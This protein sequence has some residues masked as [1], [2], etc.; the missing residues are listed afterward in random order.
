MFFD[1]VKI[2]VDGKEYIFSSFEEASGYKYMICG[3]QANEM[4]EGFEF[5]EEIDIRYYQ[6]GNQSYYCNNFIRMPYATCEDILKWVKIVD[7][8]GVW[9]TVSMEEIDKYDQLYCIAN[10]GRENAANNQSIV[11]T[12]RI[13]TAVANSDIEKVMD[14]EKKDVDNLSMFTYEINEH[15][16][17]TITGYTG[18]ESNVIIPEEI[19]GRKVEIIG[20]RA[21]KQSNTIESITLPNS[22][23]EI[24]AWAFKNCAR[25]REV[26][27]SDGIVLIGGWA[28]KDCPQLNMVV[29]PVSVNT[30]QGWAFEGCSDNLQ[31]IVTNGS[32]AEQ[33]AISEGISYTYN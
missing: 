14:V 27:M 23:L 19:E 3:N 15:G 28:F 26:V 20:E 6:L 9:N 21:F 32:Y 18:A 29:L 11:Q 4:L 8:A 10:P 33:Y 30:I 25:L 16:S 31:F 24:Q 22:I 5:A 17:I 1:T 7:A 2:A 13:S 12:K